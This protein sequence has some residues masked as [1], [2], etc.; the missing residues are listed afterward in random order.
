MPPPK[1]RQTVPGSDAAAAASCVRA[2]PRPPHPPLGHGDHVGRWAQ[3]GRWTPPPRAPPPPP[4]LCLGAPAA[5]WAAMTGHAVPP[6]Q[7]RPP[8]RA[9]GGPATGAASGGRA[10]PAPSPLSWPGERAGKEKSGVVHTA[11]PTPRRLQPPLHWSG[12]PMARAAM[13]GRVAA[14]LPPLPPSTQPPPPP[15]PLQPRPLALLRSLPPPPRPP[16]PPPP[17]S[18]PPPLRSGSGVLP[19]FATLMATL[20][21]RV[22]REWTE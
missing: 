5:A 19:S 20:N 7:P 22:E 8:P 16:Q 6:A 21:E 2:L 9:R 17:P 4:P 11:L 10:A 3:D 12:T 13:P 15:G 14:P 18:P 1:A